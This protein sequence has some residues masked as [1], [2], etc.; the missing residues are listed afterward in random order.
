MLR[1][2]HRT[3]TS[4]AHYRARARLRPNQRAR[5]RTVRAMA[6]RE[7]EEW[8]RM[9]VP[10]GDARNKAGRRPNRGCRQ[11]EISTSWWLCADRR[12]R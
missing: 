12:Q 1:C 2:P 10:M 4:D 6:I 5:R 11:P 8:R 3:E 9:Q 7:H